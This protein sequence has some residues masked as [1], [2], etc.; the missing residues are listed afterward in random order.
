MAWKRRKEQPISENCPQC[1]SD[2][3]KRCDNDEEFECSK[4]KLRW[5]IVVPE[6][7][8]GCHAKKDDLS[9]YTNYKHMDNEAPDFLCDECFRNACME[10]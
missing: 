10:E 3:I 9:P 5:V 7:C 4:C 2:R 6:E 8:D 1:Q